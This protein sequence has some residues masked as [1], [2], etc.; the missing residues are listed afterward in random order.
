MNGAWRGVPSCGPCPPP[1]VRHLSPKQS[2]DLDAFLDEQLEDLGLSPAEEAHLRQRIRQIAVDD[3][4][5]RGLRPWPTAPEAPA[6]ATM[7]A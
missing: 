7:A 5:G 3:L 4:Q 2:A 1:D 6:V